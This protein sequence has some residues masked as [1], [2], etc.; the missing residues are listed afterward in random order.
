MLCL[1]NVSPVVWVY[2]VNTELYIG[3]CGRVN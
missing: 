1:D 3:E 2:H